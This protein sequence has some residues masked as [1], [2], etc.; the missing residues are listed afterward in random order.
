MAISMLSDQLQKSIV[1][2]G[3]TQGDAC[4]LHPPPRMA[5]N[6]LLLTKD[7]FFLPSGTVQ[8]ENKTES[9]D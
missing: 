6:F 7:I 2:S 4:S 3:E 5:Y 9:R 1:G 8:K